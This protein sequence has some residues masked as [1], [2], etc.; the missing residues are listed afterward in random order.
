[1]SW[2]VISAEDMHRCSEMVIIPAKLCIFKVSKKTLKLKKKSLR[3]NSKSFIL[4]VYCHIFVHV[5]TDLNRTLMSAAANMAGLFPPKDDQVW[6]KGFMWQPV[7]IHSI[8]QVMD[9]VL[10][11]GKPCQRYNQALNDYLQSAE[12]TDLLAKYKN[13]F[14]YLEE[15]SGSEIRSFEDA[16]ILYNTLWIENLKNKG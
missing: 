10:Y 3:F 7:P 6:K 12:H 9:Y 14:A 5:G 15:N 16:E 8:P 11:M 1:M 13:L 4:F 2:A